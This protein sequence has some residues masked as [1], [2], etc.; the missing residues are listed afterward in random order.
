MRRVHGLR[1]AGSG[2]GRVTRGCRSRGLSGLFV[3]RLGNNCLR[4]LGKAFVSGNSSSWLLLVRAVRNLGIAG[5]NGDGASVGV[6]L[7]RGT[8]SL[9][10]WANSSRDLDTRGRMR[11]LG[12]GAI[13]NGLRA[14]GNGLRVGAGDDRC[15]AVGIGPVVLALKAVGAILAARVVLSAAAEIDAG[16]ASQDVEAGNA[17]SIVILAIA[18][19]NGSGRSKESNDGCLHGDKTGR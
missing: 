4:L 19:A 12:V 14:L 17:D 2:G 13:I 9:G 10:H 8:S 15:G 18:G 5:G 6:L 3:M 16:E 11:L 7:E 1:L